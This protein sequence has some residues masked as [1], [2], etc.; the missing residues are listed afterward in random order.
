MSLCKIFWRLSNKALPSTYFSVWDINLVLKFI[1]LDER[2][3]F[4]GNLSVPFHTADDPIHVV[5][6]HCRL[7]HTVRQ[8]P[9]TLVRLLCINAR[10][11]YACVCVCAVFFLCECGSV[12]MYIV[13]EYV[14]IY[15]YIFTHI[16][17]YICMHAIHAHIYVYQRCSD[18]EDYL[19]LNILLVS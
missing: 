13:H 15:T 18:I 11:D 14:H 2:C 3:C 12:C 8:S 1:G 17:I 10:L 7:C 6:G 19:C 5:T 4:I 16:Y 9:A